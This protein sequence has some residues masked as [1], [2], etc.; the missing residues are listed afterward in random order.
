MKTCLSLETKR[1]DLNVQIGKAQ[2]TLGKIRAAFYGGMF[3]KTMRTM[4]TVTMLYLPPGR[5]VTYL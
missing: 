4:Q 2:C 1:K 3:W 5:R